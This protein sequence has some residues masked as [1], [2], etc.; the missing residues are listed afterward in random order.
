MPIIYN[1]D[2]EDWTFEAESKEEE[3]A[4]IKIGVAALTKEMAHAGVFDMFEKGDIKIKDIYK[5]SDEE[6]AEMERDIAED[7]KKSTQD[8]FEDLK[9]GDTKH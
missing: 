5:V 8:F 7:S 2:T 1:Q 3:I 4:L 6:V 9:K